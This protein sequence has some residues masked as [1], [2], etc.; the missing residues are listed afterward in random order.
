MELLGP[1][2][3]AVAYRWALLRRD[4]AKRRCGCVMPAV[5]GEPLAQ[6]PTAFQLQPVD[7]IAM[8]ASALALALLQCI[9]LCLLT[10]GTGCVSPIAATEWLTRVRSCHALQTR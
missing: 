1:L 9:W 8:S 6:Y 7:V 3:T 2:C 4:T 5:T 10:S